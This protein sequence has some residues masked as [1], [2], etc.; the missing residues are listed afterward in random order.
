MLSQHNI[1][2]ILI[3]KIITGQKFGLFIN[4]WNGGNPILHGIKTKNGRG[5]P[6]LFMGAAH[7]RRNGFC[8]T[9]LLC[10]SLLLYVLPLIINPEVWRLLF[11]HQGSERLNNLT[12]HTANKWK[13]GTEKSDFFLPKPQ[14]H[15]DSILPRGFPYKSRAWVDL[16]YPNGER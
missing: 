4:I 13:G 12:N 7:W 11:R 14:C 10:T 6:A 16:I 2:T 3:S 15:T 9:K 5:V 8:F 1:R